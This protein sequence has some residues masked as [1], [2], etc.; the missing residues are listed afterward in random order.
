M[1]ENFWVVGSILTTGKCFCDEHECS[2]VSGRFSIH[3][4]YVYYKYIMY[5]DQFSYSLVAQ[6]NSFLTGACL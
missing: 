2:P 5:F 1:G 6:H 4:N 3:C